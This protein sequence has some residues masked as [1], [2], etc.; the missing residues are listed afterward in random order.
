MLWQPLCYHFDSF[1]KSRTAVLQAEI[2]A[3]PLLFN[4]FMT[5]TADETPIYN[6]VPGYEALRKTLDAKLAEHNESNTVMDLVLFQQVPGTHLSPKLGHVSPSRL[7]RLLC[8]FL[9]S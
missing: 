8:H 7:P 9:G 2:E 5:M 4:N 6:S 1:F 3:R